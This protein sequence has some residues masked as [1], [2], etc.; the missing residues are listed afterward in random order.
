[1][2]QSQFLIG[3]PLVY[4]T[5]GSL[6]IIG[7]YC[8]YLINVIRGELFYEKFFLSSLLFIYLRNPTNPTT[9]EVLFNKKKIY[10]SVIR[11]KFSKK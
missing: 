5:P 3:V 6:I 1:M 11:Y 7:I 8:D 4:L 9:M 10:L 2:T